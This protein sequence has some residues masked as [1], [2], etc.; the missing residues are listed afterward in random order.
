MNALYLDAEAQIWDPVDGIEDCLAGRVR[1]VGEAAARVAEDYLRILR[2]YRFQ[3]HY[4]TAEADAAARAACRTGAHGLARLSGERIRHEMMRLLA[5]PD[6]VPAFAMLVEDGIWSAL[7]AD[8]CNPDTD[9]D[10]F[11]RL[12]QLEDDLLEDGLPDPI[13]R[14]AYLMRLARGGLANGKPADWRF[15]NDELD[16]LT[17]LANSRQDLGADAAAARRAIWQAGKSLYRDG[18]LLAAAR[19]DR[20]KDAARLIAIAEG[21]DVP[22]L[23]I[24]GADLVELG[25]L[26]GPGLG[27]LLRAVEAWWIACDFAPDR[28][29][30]MAEARRL[31]G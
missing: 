27:K 10:G 22:A 28:T 31:L 2:F 11:Q 4:G 13:R 7:N 12:V 20:T 24:R 3:A 15:S 14:L 5:A 19:Q 30:C 9:L 16:R 26:P 29:A 18:V 21:W 23:P 17:A 25:V 8:R 1:F 6:P